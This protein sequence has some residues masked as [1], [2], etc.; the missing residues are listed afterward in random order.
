ME[1]LPPPPPLP[2]ASLSSGQKK[3][4]NKK[5]K[6]KGLSI[7]TKL[8]KLNQRALGRAERKRKKLEEKERVKNEKLK[9]KLM[10]KRLKEARKRR[11]LRELQQRYEEKEGR[12]RELLSEERKNESDNLERIKEQEREEQLRLKGLQEDK[13]RKNH[14][15]ELISCIKKRIKKIERYDWVPKKDPNKPFLITK[16]K[17]KRILQD[18]GTDREITEESRNI[19]KDVREYENLM[20]NKKIR[21]SQSTL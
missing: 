10:E 18:L 15:R 20:R 2:P 13:K 9:N 3:L 19:K 11:K 1:D 12:R 16:G 6:K 21:I 7:L 17:E 5:E 4:H 14:I 8:H